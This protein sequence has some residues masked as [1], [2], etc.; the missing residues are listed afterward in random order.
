M[1]RVVRRK[2]ARPKNSKTRK[3]AVAAGFR[4]GFEQAIAGAL[5]EAGMEFTYESM[6]VNYVGKPKFY[7]PDFIL[8]NDII[9]EV[10]GRFTAADRV[11][12]LLVKE[13]HPDLDIRFVFQADNP[14]VTGSK[15]RYSDWCEKNGFKYCF[16][17]IPEEW[18]L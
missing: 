7:K 16:V 6:R 13:Q 3:D 15:T 1:R 18:Y 9:L 8:A 10:K 4:S 17:N 11:K 2:P 5:M 12:H 14:I